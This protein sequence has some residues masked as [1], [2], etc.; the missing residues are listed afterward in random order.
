MRERGGL[1][2]GGKIGYR[3][4]DHGGGERRRRCG[5]AGGW[6]IRRIESLVKLLHFIRS[7]TNEGLKPKNNKSDWLEKGRRWRRSNERV[8]RCATQFLTRIHSVFWW[9]ALPFYFLKRAR[10]T[11]LWKMPN[12]PLAT[13]SFFLSPVEY[14]SS[15][16]SRVLMLFNVHCSRWKKSCT[17]ER[18][19]K[20]SDTHAA[21]RQ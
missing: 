2:G 21:E 11:P 15:L 19:S 6:F 4:L 13:C 7:T 17:I 12:F 18:D 9:A 14:R 10:S 16:I 20:R 5:N 1:G 3:T 8:I